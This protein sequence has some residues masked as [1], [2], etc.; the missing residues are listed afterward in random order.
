M[1]ANGDVS[2]IPP[3]FHPVILGRALILYG[4]YEQAP[5]I[6]G[7]G[8]EIYGE[9]LARLENSQLPNQRYSRYQSTGS[10]FDVNAGGG[11]DAIFGDGTF[12]VAPS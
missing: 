5:E 9:Y 7:Q 10:F 12:T 11:G 1:A 6:K 2:P 4:N 3:Q 8:Q